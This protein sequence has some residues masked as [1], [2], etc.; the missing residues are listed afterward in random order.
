MWQALIELVLNIT[1][2]AA[3]RRPSRPVGG[4]NQARLADGKTFDE[5]LE[6]IR[7]ELTKLRPILQLEVVREPEGTRTEGGATLAN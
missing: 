7:F 2:L 3:L 1:A 6:R 5:L 4:R